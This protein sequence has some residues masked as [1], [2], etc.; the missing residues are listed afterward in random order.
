G[1][2]TG[3]IA[4]EIYGGG[5]GK[6]FILGAATAAAGTIFNDLFHRTWDSAVNKINNARQ[7]FS[8][9]SRNFITK[10][11]NEKTYLRNA[12]IGA[13][14][15]SG[16]GLLSGGPLA[17]LLLGESGFFVGFYGSFLIDSFFGDP[18]S[19]FYPFYT[20]ETTP[21]PDVNQNGMAD[22]FE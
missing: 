1:G 2:V 20:S 17:A 15:G 13:T 6:G 18:A 8:E 3:G 10:N 16:V 5:F 4:S 19:F 12:G 21:T 14:A 7:A 11:F 9:R 22:V